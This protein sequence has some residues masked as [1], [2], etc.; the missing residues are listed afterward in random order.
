MTF[1]RCACSDGDRVLAGEL[2]R[3]LHR[4]G[5]AGDEE[6]PVQPLG[7]QRG[8]L[9]RQPLGRLGLEVQA[10]AEGGLLHLSAHRL[11]HRLVA[12][13]DVAD[14][15]ARRA[16]EVALAVDVPHVDA[17]R[18]VEHRAAPPRLV[19]E[20]APRGHHAASGNAAQSLGRR[21]SATLSP[22]RN[23]R[24]SIM[25]MAWNWVSPTRTK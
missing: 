12:V 3:A 11:Q 22:S 2:H 6:H 10:V 8:G 21:A 19:E 24:S 23:G 25:L 7:R 1:H 13:A 9:G 4:L 5:P 14:H 15:R 20:V 18:L 17:A 16:V